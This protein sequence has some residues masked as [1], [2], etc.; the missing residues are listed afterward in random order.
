MTRRRRSL[1]EDDLELWRRVA[2]STTP[3]EKRPAPPAQLPA[4]PAR[5]DVHTDPG[6]DTAPL[7]P[8]QLGQTRRTEAQ[9]HDL[10][11]TIERSLATTPLRMDKKTFGKLKKGKMRPERKLDLHGMTLAEAHPRLNT[12]I[13]SA[14]ADGCRLVI[15]VT[16]KGKS[17][18]DDG[19]PIPTPRGVLRHQVPG[20]L[21]APM[22]R[23]FV[24]QVTDAHLRHGG[25]G[26]YYVYL[27]RGPAG[28][29]R[30]S[31]SQAR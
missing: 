18:R 4:A 17:G 10:S 22:L 28:Q 1:T 19:G 5:K 3:L 12:F 25:S 26:A 13:R 20:W 24:L 15:V 7:T 23:P 30:Q 29:A 27:T 8:F 2:R 9:G 6:H 31:G 21:H 16:G 11:P 14:H